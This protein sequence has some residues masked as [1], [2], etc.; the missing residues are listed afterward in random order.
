MVT[1]MRRIGCVRSSANGAD[2][3]T[4]GF[5]IC[6][7]C[8]VLIVVLCA[9]CVDAPL[10]EPLNA[11]DHARGQAHSQSLVQ[12]AE[13]LVQAERGYG[14]LASNI[15]LT[16]TFDW[17]DV[18]PGHLG[19]WEWSGMT[20]ELGSVVTRIPAHYSGERNWA[21]YLEGGP[22]ILRETAILKPDIAIDSGRRVL[23]LEPAGVELGIAVEVSSTDG[24]IEKAKV[25]VVPGV[26]HGEALPFL[27]AEGITDGNG[28]CELR[29][30]PFGNWHVLIS[31]AGYAPI[32]FSPA[33]LPTDEG[34]LKIPVRLTKSVMVTVEGRPEIASPYV[35][36]GWK[37][38]V[39]NQYSESAAAVVKGKASILLPSTCE[40]YVQGTS[41]DG[42]E[43]HY[44]GKLAQH[45]DSIVVIIE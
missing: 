7:A 11:G 20:D 5:Q 39:G 27:L 22:I 16:C 15:L 24:A 30:I 45:R 3:E 18:A 36:Y 34:I 12:T 42:R 38:A 19:R 23:R 25:C 4:I 14:K 43:L 26:P 10:D 6:A 17:R 13:F 33:V 2:L 8:L 40:Y 32:K 29:G 9:G 37:P 28:V 41:K 44:Q 31:K 21:A 1:R 35:E